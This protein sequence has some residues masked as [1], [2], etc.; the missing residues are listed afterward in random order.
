MTPEGVERRRSAALK[1]CLAGDSAVG[2]TS[3]IKR[4]VSNTFDDRYIVTLGAKVSSKAFTVEDPMQPGVV[5]EVNASIWDIMGNVGFREVLKDAYFYQV[6]GILLVCDGTRPE[7]FRSL[8]AWFNAVRSVAGSVPAIVLVNKSDLV[9]HLR[10]SSKEL[11]EFCAPRGWR[12]LPTSA[13]TGQN[14]EQAFLL[15]A[16]LYLQGLKRVPA[17][18]G[19]PA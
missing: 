15:M 7:T 1:I 11:E 2:K 5:R 3:L 9:D 10:V 4:F 8:P 16:E 14:V 17:R 6:Q 12:W 18:P 19:A 13:K